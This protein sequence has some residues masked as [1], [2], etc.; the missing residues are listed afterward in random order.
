MNN[1]V[2]AF[3][4]ELKKLREENERFRRI[5]THATATQRECVYFICG[6]SGDRDQMGLP[7]Q[8][9]ICPAHG[10]DV[11]AVYTKTQDCG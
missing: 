7:Y 2:E 9:L 4:G 11:M 3:P 1:E 8:V 6:E 10:L 5:I